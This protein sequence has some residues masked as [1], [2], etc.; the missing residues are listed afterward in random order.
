MPRQHRVHET[1]ESMA[2]KEKA[3]A[4]TDVAAP[5]PST[6]QVQQSHLETLS[7][8]QLTQ[9]QLA[10]MRFRRHRLAMIGTSIL[11]FMALMAIFAP[12]I[13]PENIY[14]PMSA[15]IF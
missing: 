4:T 9:Y 10:W 1:E 5:L 8:K 13:S 12:L 6:T 15:D 7:T 11:L 14:D 3:P 2:L